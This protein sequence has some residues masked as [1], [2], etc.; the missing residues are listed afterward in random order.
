MDLV[1]GLIAFYLLT[2]FFYL[3]RNLGKP[4]PLSAS[5]PLCRR[6]DL[7]LRSA[8]NI[9]LRQVSCTAR[10]PTISAGPFPELPPQPPLAAARP[11]G[12][13]S[14]GARRFWITAVPASQQGALFAPLRLIAL[15]KA[16]P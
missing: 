4:I 12:R 3:G 1:F 16:L 10:L 2:E 14:E 13:R 6:P 5:A 8:P 15:I 7:P 11:A 9:C